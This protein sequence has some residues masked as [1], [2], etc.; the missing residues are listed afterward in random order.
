[1]RPNCLSCQHCQLQ[2]DT[3]FTLVSPVIWCDVR[4]A[5]PTTSVSAA[6]RALEETVCGGTNERL[7]PREAESKR[8]ELAGEPTGRR[9]L[10]ASLQTHGAPSTQF[11]QG[12]AWTPV[13][14]AYLRAKYQTPVDL[15]TVAGTLSRT[16]KATYT[17]ARLLGLSDKAGMRREFGLR[18]VS[19]ERHSR[20]LTWTPEQEEYIQLASKEGRWPVGGRNRN[21]AKLQKALVEGVNAL[22][23]AHTWSAIRHRLWETS[24][25]GKRCRMRQSNKHPLRAIHAP[26]IARADALAA[27]EKTQLPPKDVVLSAPR[28]RAKKRSEGVTA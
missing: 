6:K 13:A 27:T 17:R 12:M 4:L 16:P 11:G 2:P 1:M 19:A 26:L 23:P 18:V 8:L 22:G 7:E 5:L 15:Q 14:V 28:T 9:P 20:P 25:G 10:G 21:N 3:D 24:P